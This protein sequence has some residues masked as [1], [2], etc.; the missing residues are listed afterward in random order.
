[1]KKNASKGSEG[2]EASDDAKEEGASPAER[3]LRRYGERERARLTRGTPGSIHRARVDASHPLGFGLGD[4]YFALKRSDTAF[5]YLDEDDGWN[6][7]TLSTG[8]PVSGFM[9]HEAQ[10]AIAETLVFGTQPLDE[11]TVVYFTGDP[12][13]R[14][15]WYSG[16]VALAN[17]VFM[18]GND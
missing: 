17:A 6:V 3:T 4:T 11:G 9:G 7:A 15:F 16:H 18:V 10:Q 13:F 1:L 5:A 14:G 2:S 12:L 8:T